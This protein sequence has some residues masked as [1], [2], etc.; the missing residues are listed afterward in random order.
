[1]AV[2]L[3]KERREMEDVEEKLSIPIKTEAI[4]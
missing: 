3:K 2:N 4:K 1:M